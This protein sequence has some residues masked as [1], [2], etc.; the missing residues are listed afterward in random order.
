MEALTAYIQSVD[1]LQSAALD[2]GY[3][4]TRIART[5]FARQSLFRKVGA[6]IEISAYTDADVTGGQGREPAFFTVFT[7]ASII[8]STP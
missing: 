6:A 1:C 8:P 7:I 5:H 3:V 2:I 4:F